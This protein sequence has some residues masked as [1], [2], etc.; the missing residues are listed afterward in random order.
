MG[1]GA[2]LSSDS[3]SDS[4]SNSN[5]SKEVSSD[6]DLEL[7]QVSEQEQARRWMVVSMW[8]MY[9]TNATI[10]AFDDPED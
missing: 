6:S 10:P 5:P 4:N 1:W 3:E 2:M 8:Q 7:E 9:H